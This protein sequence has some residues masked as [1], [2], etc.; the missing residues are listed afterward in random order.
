MLQVHPEYWSTNTDGLYPA[1]NLKARLGMGLYR[2]EEILMYVALSCLM[3]R[4]MGVCGFKLDLCLHGMWKSIT[5]RGWNA[6][7]KRKSKGVGSEVKTICDGISRLMI[8]M[9]INERKR[10]MKN[11]KS[12]IQALDHKKHHWTKEKR[13]DLHGDGVNNSH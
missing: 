9:E 5:M 7:G 12:K 1:P 10:K 6:N 13:Y 4:K 3:N 11:K 8:G 2:Y